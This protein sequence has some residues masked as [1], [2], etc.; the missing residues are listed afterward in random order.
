MVSELEEYD[1]VSLQMVAALEGDPVVWRRVTET[2]RDAMAAHALRTTPF[3]RRLRPE[4]LGFDAMP[5][6]TRERV[7]ALGDDL[8][9]QGIP[10][11]RRVVLRTSGSTG[12]PLE[13]SRDSTQGPAEDFSAR[14]VL[15]R[16][17]GIPPSATAAWVALRPVIRQ[18]DLSP[19]RG[20]MRRALAGAVARGA[21]PPP[22]VLA[23]PM[24]GVVPSEV[25]ALVRR[26]RALGEYFVYGVASAIDWVA[27]SLEA[28][29]SAPPHPPV[30]V[31]TTAETLTPV[32][33]LRMERVF[34]CPVHSWY[35]S[36]EFNGY[37]AAT[38]PGSRRYAFNPLLVDVE[39]LDETDAPV[40][41][42]ALGRLVL[43]DLG[44]WASP[45]IRYD[46][47]DVATGPSGSLG[48]WP[49]VESIEG[50]SSEV[51]RFPSG[52]AV[53]GSR[54]GQP[55][56]I[57]NDFVSLIRHFQ[58]VQTGPNELE[59]RL[60][61]ARE[62]TAGELRDV[63]RAVRAVV[64]PDTTIRIRSVEALERLPSGKAW[65]VR[66]DV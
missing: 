62:P 18:P 5:V 37:L 40:R 26:W 58:G 66:R 61:W 24:L 49:L 51:L 42:G 47:G 41:P 36:R 11:Q 14:R 64:D 30:C 19:R 6:L 25:P 8:I 45:R 38:L 10:P 22:K 9:A 4:P 2:L 65:I 48:G 35:G 3:Y 52:R 56:F 15:R 34:G 23:V 20:L 27:E 29:G 39:V 53:S 16:L 63:E 54:L 1:P 43:T 31:V 7:R 46:T 55:L 21:R 57:L 59:L 60:V 32:A 12:D 17:H 33:R 13:L 28:H 50:R 44:N